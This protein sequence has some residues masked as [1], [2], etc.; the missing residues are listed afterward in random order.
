MTSAISAREDVKPNLI[1]HINYTYFVLLLLQATG[2]PKTQR[3]STEFIFDNLCD[4]SKVLVEGF[5]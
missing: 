5:G 4:N 3:V 2:I 1:S